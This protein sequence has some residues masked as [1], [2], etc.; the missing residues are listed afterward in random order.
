M[1]T[2]IHCSFTVRGGISSPIFVVSAR[3]E[4]SPLRLL[5]L[6][7]IRIVL[8]F[9]SAELKSAPNTCTFHLVSKAHPIHGRV[10]GG[11]YGSENDHG[12]RCVDRGTA[13]A[14]VHCWLA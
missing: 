13:A 1:R 8:T 10:Y 11:L 7:F 9:I 6:F 14:T 12:R 2:I 5:L 4:D 3:L